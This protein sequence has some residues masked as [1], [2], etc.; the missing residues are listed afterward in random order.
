MSIVFLCDFS[1]LTPNM[2]C[3]L[4]EN[5]NTAATLDGSG[6]LQGHVIPLSSEA[7][8]SF[9]ISDYFAWGGIEL[10]FQLLIFGCVRSYMPMLS[11]NIIDHNRAS[12]LVI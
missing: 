12:G 7:I 3:Q 9:S 5:T 6:T 4:I 2:E 11:E 10:V 1:Q 8:N